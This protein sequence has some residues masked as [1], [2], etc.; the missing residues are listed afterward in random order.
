MKHKRPP[1]TLRAEVWVTGILSRAPRNVE[2]AFAESDDTRIAL[3]FFEHSIAIGKPIPDDVRE[4]LHRRGSDAARALLEC[5]PDVRIGKKRAKANQERQR[6]AA[7][8][9]G[10]IRAA[11]GS[12]IAADPQLRRAKPYKL[13]TKLIEQFPRR[14]WSV[15][16][17]QRALGRKK[18]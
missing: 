11:A 18:K 17:A 1:G 14:G 2:R 10:E 3:T 15:R 9:Y 6:C 16:T 13:A 5:A 4:L 7:A 12:L 8:K